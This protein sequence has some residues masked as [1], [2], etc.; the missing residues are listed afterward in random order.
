MTAAESDARRIG[1]TETDEARN[2]AFGIGLVADVYPVYADLRAQGPALPGSI[3][4]HFP[5]PAS[6]TA[7]A[8]TAAVYS[9]ELASALLK[10]H[11][12][13]SSHFY[14]ML[15]RAIGPSLI[16]MDEPDHRRMR[17]LLQGAFSKNEMA[18]WATDIIQPVVDE[19][20]GAIARRGFA[21]LYSEVGAKVPIHTTVAALGLAESDRQWF[22]DQA[23]AMT[24]D[25]AGAGAAVAATAI[26]DYIAP[27]VAERR[28]NPGR[29]L[30]SVLTTAR[31]SAADHAAGVDVR[32]LTDQ[33]INTFVRLLVI[34]GASTTF[35]AYANMMYALLTHPDQFQRVV[36]DR[37]LAD[38][39][40]E[41]SLRW[42]Q[43]LSSLGRVVT[44]DTTLG[45][46]AVHAGETVEASIG[47]ANHDPAR[48]PVPDRFDIS[49]PRV[50]RHLTFGWG[51][52][53]CLGVHLAR[54]ELRIMLDRTIEL[55]P[56]LR[57]DPAY[58]VPEVS[59]LGFRV[60]SP[61]H[62]VFTP[63][64]ER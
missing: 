5:V 34:A 61:L 8:V 53:R 52:H 37:S 17:A 49:R 24:S 11:E 9:H 6:P 48:W 3:A 33:E 18:W 43:P 40:V 38:A 10:D 32:P 15:D 12:A 55:L 44:R 58:P 13:Y 60:A 30:L 25:H 45:G 50:D 63:R 62:V 16:G 21:D 4:G 19:H 56:D 54:T 42:E 2:R 14:V 59:G 35:R 64:G 51:V 46:L 22:F 23:L 1:T 26:S 28:E 57:L 29:D 41:E 27:L 20:L 39:A 47:A 31:V 7:S 36:A